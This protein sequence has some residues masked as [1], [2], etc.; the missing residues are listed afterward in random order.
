[1]RPNLIGD[2]TGVFHPL[3][4]ILITIA[5]PDHLPS[6]ADAWDFECTT[7]NGLAFKK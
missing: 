6:D 3:W 2:G 7:T 1:M 5:C 4:L